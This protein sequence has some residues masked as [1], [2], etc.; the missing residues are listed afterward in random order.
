VKKKVLFTLMALSLMFAPAVMLAAPAA[1]GPTEVDI[2]IKPGSFPNSINLNSKGVIPVAILTTAV[3][4]ATDVDPTTVLFAGAEPVRWA[5]ED[6]D[7]DGDLDLVLHFKTQ[8]T[9][10]T[11]GATEA[12]LT[13][14]T[15][16]GVP[17]S[18]VDSVRTVPS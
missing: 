5:V 6:V 11:V 12:T 14:E 8:E 18:V 13:G 3:F 4:D 7:G 17:F 10:W 2:D 9:I 1:A 16:A 15:Y